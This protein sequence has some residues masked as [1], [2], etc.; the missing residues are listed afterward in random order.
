MIELPLRQLASHAPIWMPVCGASMSPLLRPGDQVLVDLTRSWV[1]GDV[2]VVGARRGLVVHRIVA[3]AGDGARVITKGDAVS[4]CDRPMRS[5]A[6][7]GVV[8]RVRRR[9]WWGWWQEMEVSRA[10]GQS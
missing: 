6:I 1:C 9:H 3:V 10:L 8:I 7:V 5:A 2:V 4:H